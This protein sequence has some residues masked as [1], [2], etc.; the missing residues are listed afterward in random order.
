MSYFEKLKVS[1]AK[2]HHYPQISLRAVRYFNIALSTLKL[3]RLYIKNKWFN[4]N[5]L[6][7]CGEKHTGSSHQLF[8]LDFNLC[9]KRRRTQKVN[10][11]SERPAETGNISPNVCTVLIDL[12]FIKYLSL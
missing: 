9:P 8:V 1:L 10:K 4:V 2:K 7:T 12:S 5:H 3:C 11:L 6:V